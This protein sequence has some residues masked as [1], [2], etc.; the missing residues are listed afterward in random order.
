MIGVRRLLCKTVAL[1]LL[2]IPWSRADA[3]VVWYR[4]P[5]DGTMQAY[6]VYVPSGPPPA[7]GYP[8]IFHGHGYGWSVSG[9]FSAWQRQWADQHG[10][11]LININARGPTFYEGIGQQAVYEVVADACRRFGLD[12]SRLF[13][14][15]GSMGGTGAFRQGVRHPEIFAAAA[16]VDGWADWRLW[17]HHWYARTDMRDAIEEFRRPLLN[18]VAPLYWAE[19]AMWGRVRAIV[20][21]R[22]TV[23]WPDN[24]LRLAQR[25]SE[26][27]G[28]WP[29]TYRTDTVLNYD[30]GH[31]GG[32]DLRR[33]Y[34]F[35]LRC[36]PASLGNKV[37]IAAW[38]LAYAR[39]GWLAITQIHHFGQRAKAESL[40]R[41]GVISV[42]TENVNRIEVAIADCPGLGNRSWCQVY[43]DGWLVYEGPPTLLGAEAVWGP[44]DQLASWRPGRAGPWE[45]R[46]GLEG[47]IGDV[48]VQPFTVAYATSGSARHTARHK[49]EAHAFARGWNAFFVHGPGVRA[50]PEDWV[51]TDLLKRR[52][53]VLFGCLHCSRLLRIA[54]RIRRLPIRIDSGVVTVEDGTERRDYRGPQFGAFFVYPN[55][56]CEGKRYLVVCSGRWNTKP[57]KQA[58]AGLEYDLEKLPWA[59]PDYVV[60]NSDQKQLPFVLNVNNKPPVTCYEAAYFTEAGFFDNHWRLARG[61]V[62]NWVKATK[63]KG[64]RLM[65]VDEV[66]K[67]TPL[68]LRIVSDDG[69]AV[70]K[71]RVTVSDGTHTVSAVTD[72]DGWAQFDS[73]VPDRANV[74]SVMA[75]GCAYDPDGNCPWAWPAHSKIGNLVALKYLGPRQV[76]MNDAPVRLRWQL[77]NLADQSV[78]VQLSPCSSRGEI[79]PRRVTVELPPA[80]E[81]RVSF[82]WLDGTGTAGRMVVTVDAEA[83]AGTARASATVHD[84]VQV[85]P[86]PPP[87]LVFSD[88]K[89]TREGDRWT[90]TAMLTNA[91]E[92]DVEADVE[93]MVVEAAWPCGR[94]KVRLR[95]GERARLRWT[96]PPEAGYCHAG[97]AR[98]VLSVPGTL[99]WGETEVV[100][101][102]PGGESIAAVP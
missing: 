96:L 28:G 10:W 46:P 102:P 79:R 52:N 36:A 48:F 56:L 6:G 17:H 2:A 75:T 84:T 86:L 16:S 73:I 90:I 35:F 53:L 61:T 57:D 37:R 41:N 64:A 66:A 25:L 99:S 78:T 97:K 22:D 24:S 13:F 77:A 7:R 38:R 65:H 63:P 32:Y 3:A 83:L 60:F 50:I 70:E 74:L 85:L 67:G 9:S 58:L 89:A 95:P 4:S 100:L 15:G 31:G 72:R 8:A 81:S 21:G 34:D 27:S 29:Y 43:I 49:E 51:D 92:R 68:R 1:L 91:T 23:V 82:D 30:K 14:T 59:Y 18:S 33:I 80:S 87:D 69:K 42:W 45:K 54:D 55:P 62:A 26:L 76:Q 19:R 47:P 20:D 44:D 88:I 101:G 12:R 40:V 5:V 11:V 98:V 93:A 39:Q 94:Q 71:A